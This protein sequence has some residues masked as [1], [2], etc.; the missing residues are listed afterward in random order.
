[1]RVV[2]KSIKFQTWQNLAN[3]SDGN[4]IGNDF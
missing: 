3:T 2:S 1:V 4:V